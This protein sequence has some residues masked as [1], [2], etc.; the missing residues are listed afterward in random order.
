M[1]DAGGTQS[2]TRGIGLLKIVAEGPPEGL[3]LAQVAE[4][5]SL[6][7]ATAHRLLAALTRERL[8]EQDASH[9]YHGGVELWVL[10][11][12]ARSEEHTSEL[13]SREKLVCRLLL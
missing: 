10:G 6:H 11:E 2:I 1:D 8:L 3:R 5:A 4:R 12:A 9:R 7:R 13:Q